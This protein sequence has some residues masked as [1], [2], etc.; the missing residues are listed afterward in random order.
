M[1]LSSASRVY[2]FRLTPHQDLKKELLDFAKK[3]NISAAII[4]TCVGSLEYFNIRYANRKEGC[5]SKGY[6]EIVSLAG[7]LSKSS[8]HLHIS[9]SDSDGKTFGGHL[10]DGNLIYTTAEVAIAEMIDI[11]FERSP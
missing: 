7:T 5:E 2:V 8:A 4:V 11:S 3:N 10:L 9:V 1:A 6:F